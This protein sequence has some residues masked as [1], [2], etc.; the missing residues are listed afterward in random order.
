MQVAIRVWDRAEAARVRGH[1]DAVGT[2][3][4]GATCDCMIRRE[5]TSRRTDGPCVCWVMSGDDP[6]SYFLILIF[7]YSLLPPP[8]LPPTVVFFSCSLILFLIFS[9]LYLFCPL[10]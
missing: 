10:L 4:R 6:F 8:S 5:Q 2:R 9:V 3:P 7:Y 1:E